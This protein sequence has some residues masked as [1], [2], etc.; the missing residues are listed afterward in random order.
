MNALRGMR[1]LIG[2]VLLIASGFSPDFCIAQSLGEN[3]VTQAEGTPIEAEPASDSVL[4]TALG[5]QINS[6]TI[7]TRLNSLRA[8]PVDVTRGA[9]EAQ[10]YSSL[11]PAVVLVFDDQGWGSGSVIDIDGTILTNWHVIEGSNTVGVIFKPKIEGDQISSDTAILA[12][13]IK[14]DQ[15]ADLALLRL[16]E[17]PAGIKP[18][19][20]GSVGEIPIGADVHAIGHPTGESWTYTRGF[21][22]QY[23]K[24][25]EW[26]TESKVE[27][28]ADVIQTQAP[29]NPG[30]SGGPLISPNGNLV[31]VNAFSTPDAEALHFAVSV[32]EVRRFLDMESDRLAS[33]SEQS[34]AVPSP[35][36][37]DEPTDSYRNEDDSSTVFLFDID[38]DG[39][40][41]FTYTEPD[42]PNE[43]T[44]FS[45]DSSGDGMIDTLLIDENRDG[46]IEYSL[47]DVT[48]NG[49]PDLVGHYRDGE[50][51]PYKV[52]KIPG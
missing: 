52:E 1:S 47:H 7:Y 41:D 31:G 38:C 51:E 33:K 12:S 25:Y 43:A 35:D 49:E 24:N 23:R 11:S 44:F 34:Q 16:K 37:G 22:S 21:V 42:D 2:P 30:N 17:I 27:H 9:H 32:D 5:Q 19:P 46:N 36:C 6:Q 13:V 3:L 26:R 18:I 40:D 50:D 8:D 28:K 48:G 29:I 45:L 14:I 15:V 10:I 39:E 4:Q 20:L